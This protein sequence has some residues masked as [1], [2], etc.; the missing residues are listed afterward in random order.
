[1]ALEYNFENHSRKLSPGKIILAGEKQVYRIKDDRGGYPED[2]IGLRDENAD[3]VQPLAES[4]MK[5]GK[6]LFF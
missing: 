1:M 3:G 4:M 6:F 5:N 2:F